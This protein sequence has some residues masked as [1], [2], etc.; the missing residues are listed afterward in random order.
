MILAPDLV[1]VWNDKNVS[2]P[3]P[4]SSDRYRKLFR[5]NVNPTLAG[6]SPNVRDF[7]RESNRARSLTK[8]IDTSL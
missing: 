6:L 2:S 5:K 3:K 8:D 4:S 1:I 7:L